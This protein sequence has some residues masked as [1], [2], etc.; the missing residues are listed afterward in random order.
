MISPFKRNGESPAG[1]NGNTAYS[2]SP[3]AS[4]VYALPEFGL[5]DA[6]IYKVAYNDG[7]FRGSYTALS[8]GVGSGNEQITKGITTTG[9]G[10]FSQSGVDSKQIESLGIG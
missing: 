6:K 3:I 8:A 9:A 10:S 7:V 1:A 5:L 4:D 2:L